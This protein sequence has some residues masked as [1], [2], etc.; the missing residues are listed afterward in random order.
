MTGGMQ[1]HA[2][3][4]DGDVQPDLPRDPMERMIAKALITAGIRYLSDHGGTNPSRL[5]F[6]L[7]EWGVEIEVKRLHTPRV[8]EQMGRASDVIVAQGEHATAFL[9]R[10]IAA[11]GGQ[12]NNQDPA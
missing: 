1:K 5:D 8:A 3:T 12:S 6:A 7:P 9:A 2:P 10:A 11:L 4:G